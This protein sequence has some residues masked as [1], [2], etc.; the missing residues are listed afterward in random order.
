MKLSSRFVDYL[1]IGGLIAIIQFSLASY[2]FGSD[3]VFSYFSQF[4]GKIDALFGPSNT[5]TSTFFVF[6]SLLILILLGII[7]DLGNPYLT[8]SETD[9]MHIQLKKNSSWMDILINKNKEP[10]KREYRLLVNH[11][12]LNFKSRVLLKQS[13]RNKKKQKLADELSS[14]WKYQSKLAQGIPAKNAEKFAISALEEFL[15]SFVNVNTQ[16]STMNRLDDWSRVIRLLKTFTV[17]LL[18][19]AFEIIPL[20]GM[21]AIREKN[22]YGQEIELLPLFLSTLVSLMVLFYLIFGNMKLL[23]N[24]HEKYYSYLLSATYWVF[25]KEQPNS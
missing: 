12:I 25:K 24:A 8:Y 1:F 15:I 18:L 2:F 21:K 9:S 19:L 11:K 5:L 4:Y 17:I 20:V 16:N 22:I 10:I 13:P 23:R 3:T 6:S 14:L 7:F